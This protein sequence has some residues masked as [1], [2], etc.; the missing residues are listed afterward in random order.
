MTVKPYDDKTMRAFLTKAGWVIAAA[1]VRKASYTDAVKDFQR[2][3]NLG[4]ALVVDGIAGPLT[5]AAA[6]ISAKAGYKLSKNFKAT[7]FRC[8][9]GGINVGCRTIVIERSLLIALEKVRAKHYPKGLAI[10]S[11]YRCPTLNKKVGG[12]V[13]PPSH[14]VTGK[15]VDIPR[16][17][18]AKN[19]DL[20]WGLR[21]IGVTSWDRLIPG[22]SNRRVVHLDTGENRRIVFQE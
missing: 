13:S 7:E 9:C 10:V 6:N 21:G 19:I 17:V 5:A 8:G 3:Y 4:P 16:K 2:G 11:G 1:H 15:A 18:R 14:H 20:A 22:I 12:R